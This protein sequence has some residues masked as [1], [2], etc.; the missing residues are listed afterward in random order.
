MV[1]VARANTNAIPVRAQAPRVLVT[2]ADGY[3]GSV[4]CPVLAENGF[5]VTGLDTGFYRAGWLYHDGKDRPR[6]LT[7]DIRTLAPDD[8]RGYDAVVHLAELSNDP[9]GEMDQD[10]TY[11]INHHG[12]V[13]LA[14]ISRAAGVGRFVYA[15]S[16]SVYGAAGNETK[17][18]ISA[19]D[20]QTA[21]ARCKA[22]V[23]RDVG[24][25]A[26]NHF[27]PTFL[28][29]ATAFGASPRIRFDIVLNNL[30]G[31]A[32]TTGRITMTS[33]GTPWRPLVHVMDI[34]AAIVASLKAPP[35]AVWN[36]VFNVGG[37][38]NN[39]RV[40]QVAEAIGEAFP[41]CKIEM[42]SNAGDN[43]SYRVSFDKIKERLPSFLCRWTARDGAW[44]LRK[45]FES[46]Q[47][48]KPVFEGA[49]FTRLRQLRL[50]LETNQVDPQLY[51]RHHDFS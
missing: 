7:R 50:L 29:N 16:C 34:S 11:A 48:S 41:N 33:D 37:E 40:R 19:V 44:Q 20:P 9:L 43:R 12:S 2:G 35:D 39:Y 45:L 28:R 21:Y 1:A 36:E 51:W 15:S 26:N 3:I 5:E 42:G 23:E 18:E 25:L 4:L 14:A 31:V 47:L 46:I 8:L 30:A 24:A 13:R 38:G 6:I 49:P 22:L 27:C 17:T 32:W 10:N